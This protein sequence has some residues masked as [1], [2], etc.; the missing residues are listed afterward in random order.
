MSVNVN[1]A[2]ISS[3]NEMR[4]PSC[5]NAWLGLSPEH[6]YINIPRPI[7]RLGSCYPPYNLIFC[8]PRPTL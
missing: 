7:P 3:D 2:F 5:A 4:A 6:L 8:K 1:V